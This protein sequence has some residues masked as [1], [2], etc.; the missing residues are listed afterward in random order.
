M[1]LNRSPVLCAPVIQAYVTSR[2]AHFW[3]K[4]HCLNKLGSGPIGDATYQISSFSPCGFLQE[5]FIM[6][7]QCKPM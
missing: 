3:P 4:G 6:F 2:E 5:N 7:T 1:A